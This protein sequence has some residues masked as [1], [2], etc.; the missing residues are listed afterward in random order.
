MRAPARTGSSPPSATSSRRAREAILG[1]EGLKL[2]AR[3]Y[4]RDIGD[5]LVQVAG[6]FQR[7]IDDLHGADADATST[8]TPTASTAVA[9][10]LTIGGTLFILYTV[11]TGF[12]GQNFG[13]LVDN[14]DTEEGLPHCTASAASRSRP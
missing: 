13:W 2:G 14:I 5:H 9:T 12:F 3:P 10:R 7:Q 4:L 11:V 8:R 1:L 6:E